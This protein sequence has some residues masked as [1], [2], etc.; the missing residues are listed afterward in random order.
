MQ[1]YGVFASDPHVRMPGASRYLG[2]E[3]SIPAEM[4]ERIRTYTRVGDF[5]TILRD[6]C[7]GFFLVNHKYPTHQAVDFLLIQNSGSALGMECC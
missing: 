7:G 2:H 6:W 4:M 5:R 3:I 1:F